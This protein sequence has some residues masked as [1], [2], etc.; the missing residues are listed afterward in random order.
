MIDVYVVL[1]HKVIPFIEW[2]VIVA[3]GETRDEVVFP[4]LDGS[5]GGI[6]VIFVHCYTLKFDVVLAKGGF[7]V[8]GA[9]GINDV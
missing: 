5:F 9:L 2:E 8:V 1:W 4:C 3:G 6:T 7:E